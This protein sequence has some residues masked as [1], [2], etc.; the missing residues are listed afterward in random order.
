MMYLD[1]LLRNSS[2]AFELPDGTT[3]RPGDSIQP[4][5]AAAACTYPLPAAPRNRQWVAV[6]STATPFSE[7]AC[8]IGRNGKNIM[9]L[10][11][12]FVISEDGFC[13]LFLWLEEQNT[14]WVYR[15]ATGGV[16]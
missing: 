12:D 10:A 7:Y 14:W 1:Q 8:T 2:F 5:N 9:G 15:L 4:D 16:L 3:L 13:G 6:W 11:E